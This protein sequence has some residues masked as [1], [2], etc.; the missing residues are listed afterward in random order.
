[1][2]IFTEKK[3]MLDMLITQLAGS[4]SEVA[5]TSAKNI[6][7]FWL[8]A[9]QDRKVCARLQTEG[10]PITLYNLMKEKDP[11]ETKRI[12]KDFDENLLQLLIQIVLKISAGHEES[13]TKLSQ[14]V[15]E[16]I[17]NLAEIRDKVFINKVLL[18][19][20]KNEVT[21]PVALYELE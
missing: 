14:A 20:I 16:D 13:E 5:K 12:V 2:T 15:I 19:L 8:D 3:S 17:K 21:L 10:L 1:M 11:K 18:P 4:T 7:Q 9:C 6:A